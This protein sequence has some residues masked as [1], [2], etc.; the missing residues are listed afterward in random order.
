MK[1]IIYATEFEAIPFY[2]QPNPHVVI[3]YMAQ[4]NKE[5]AF[6]LGLE[7]K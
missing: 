5:Q 1:N 2:K 6:H 3:P 4:K 7:A